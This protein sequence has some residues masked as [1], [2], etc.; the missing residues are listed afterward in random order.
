[1]HGVIDQVAQL[2]GIAARDNG[3]HATEK[4]IFPSY[5]VSP[6]RRTPCLTRMAPVLTEATKKGTFG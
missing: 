4:P 2:A 1:M 5:N 6:Y 3:L